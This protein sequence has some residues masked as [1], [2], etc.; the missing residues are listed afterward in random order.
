MSDQLSLRQHE[1]E[2]VGSVLTSPDRP[3]HNAVRRSKYDLD[4]S[5]DIHSPMA[6]EMTPTAEPS[7][8]SVLI[9]Y[10]G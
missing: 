3:V 6:H 10:L 4:I 9:R 1:D 8:Q 5:P 7:M 2:A